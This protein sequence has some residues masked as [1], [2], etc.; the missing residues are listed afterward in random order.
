MKFEY[1][2]TCTC[3]V[4]DE[5]KDKFSPSEHCYGDC[6]EE[7]LDDFA[8]IT[9]S[10]SEKNTT[11]FWRISNIRLWDGDISGIAE[12]KIA[13][14]LLKAMTVNSEWII[15]G[16]V[17]DDRIEYSLSHHDAPMGSNSMVTIVS[18]EEAEKNDW[19]RY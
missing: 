1:T 5:E 14:E 17:F 18:E 16:E 6:W 8:M 2:N 7:T 15:R 19:F 12:A 13:P 9:A 3:E 4:Y 11:K 10:L